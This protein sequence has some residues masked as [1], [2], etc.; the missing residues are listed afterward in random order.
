MPCWARPSTSLIIFEFEAVSSSSS[1]RR[2]RSG[3][4]CFCTYFFR[5]KGFTLPQKPWWLSYCNGALPVAVSAVPVLLGCDAVCW[6]DWSL[7]DCCWA[8]AGRASKN[9]TNNATT[10]RFFIF[11]ILRGGAP[12]QDRLHTARLARA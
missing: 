4:V 8:S 7:V 6:D 10:A 1:L 3:W 11:D 5:A 9:A 2:S 12:S